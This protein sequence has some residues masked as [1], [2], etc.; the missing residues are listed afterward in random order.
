MPDFARKILWNVQM[1]DAAT[2]NRLLSHALAAGCSGVCIRSTSSRLAAAIARFHSA[3]LKVYAWRWPAVRTGGTSPHYFARDEAQF[4]ATQLIPNSLDG[5]IADPES[6]G[7]GQ[8]NDWNNASHTNLARDY[9]AIINNA[10]PASFAFGVTSGCRF[11]STKPDIPWREFVTASH[12]L[13]PQ[14][15]WRANLSS[16]VTNINGGT[17]SQAIT[18]GLTAWQPISAGKPIIPMAG[19]LNHIT[20]TEIN[21]YAARLLANGLNQFHFYTDTTAVSAAKLA[22]IRAI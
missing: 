10:A 9:C 22:A 11:P 3:G 6:D 15:Y 8:I 16:G 13:F 1:N 2:E 18:R 5:Y 17:P 7:A 12:T 14:S 21:D 20:V 19:E 4:V